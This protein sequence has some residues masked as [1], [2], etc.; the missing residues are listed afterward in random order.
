M[1]LGQEGG[2]GPTL[3]QLME[4]I[5]NLQEANEQS[6]KEHERLREVLRKTNEDLRS[7]RCIP[8]E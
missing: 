2:E 5:R 4:I 1:P 7:G 8:R 3:Q 6:R